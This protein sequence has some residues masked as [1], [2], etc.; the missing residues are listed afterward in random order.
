MKNTLIKSLALFLVVILAET[1][2]AQ[3]LAAKQ[4]IAKHTTDYLPEF[5]SSIVG[6]SGNANLGKIDVNV[7]FASFGNSKEE[8]E[9]GQRQLIHIKGALL[10]LNKN[11]TA[12]T[13]IEKQLKKIMIGLVSDPKQKG[14]SFKDGELVVKSNSFALGSLH[15]SE[16]VKKFLL[17]NL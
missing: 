6:Q 10:F 15:G 1:G 5:K 12:R 16:D 8:L 2:H 9:N 11:A 14:M 13:E 17:E 7:D 3:S 4:E